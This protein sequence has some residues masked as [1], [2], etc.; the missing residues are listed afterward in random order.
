MFDVIFDPVTDPNLSW[1]VIDE[2]GCEVARFRDECGAI[3]YAA[4]LNGPF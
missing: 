2:D 3:E 4:D 1:F